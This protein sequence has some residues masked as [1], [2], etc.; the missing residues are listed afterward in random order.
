[1]PLYEYLCSRCSLVTEDIF[2]SY[3]T[4]PTL[5]TCP[6][7]GG[8]AYYKVSVPHAVFGPPTMDS[9]DQVFEG[10]PP[11]IAEGAKKYKRDVLKKGRRISI[12][13]C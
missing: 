1:M 12:N 4:R 9:P 13:D 11:Q 6:T 8:S 2:E 7:C 3:R 10:H 5:L